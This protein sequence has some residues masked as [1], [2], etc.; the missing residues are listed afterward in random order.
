MTQLEDHI[1][2]L[3]VVRGELAELRLN[4]NTELKLAQD[5]WDK[6][7]VAT[8]GKTTV[9]DARRRLKPDIAEKLGN[10]KWLAQRCSEEI[11]RLDHD[12]EAASRLYT[13][14]TGS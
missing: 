5:Q 2:N 6:V 13:L 14:I 12:Q 7:E 8:T 1:W 3:A 4:A 9:A 11:A 10:A